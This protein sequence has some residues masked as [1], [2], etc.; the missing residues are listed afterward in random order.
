M[1]YNIENENV[2]ILKIDDIELFSKKILGGGIEGT[3]YEHIDAFENRKALKIL[4]RPTLLKIKKIALLSK[5][6]DSSFAFP[7]GFV[8]N[9]ETDSIMGYYMDKVNRGLYLKNLNDLIIYR[10][11][12]KKLEIIKE[13]DEAIKRAHNRGIILGDIHGK[14]ILIDENNKPKFC[15]TDNYK[16]DDYDYDIIP[17]RADWLYRVYE[18]DYSE[19]DNDKFSFGVLALNILL[20]QT[21]LKFYLT[22]DDIDIAVES[23]TDAQTKEGFRELLS[24][25]HNKPYLSEFLDYKRLSLK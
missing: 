7:Q 23:L 24:D 19:V 1:K 25:S 2:P 22:R 13:A 17:D 6:K 12:I 18:N 8:V 4:E 11:M 10:D 14:N 5:F 15:D 3:V 16:V 9:Q 21:C 20:G